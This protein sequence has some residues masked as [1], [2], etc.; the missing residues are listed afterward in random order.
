MTGQWQDATWKGQGVATDLYLLK[1]LIDALGLSLGISNLQW[2]QQEQLA[3]L[4]IFAGKQ[5][6]GELF[7]ISPKQMSI[8]DIKQTVYFAQI[9]VAALLKAVRKHP[10]VYQEI[11][12]FPSVQRDVAM[13]IDRQIPYSRV[14]EVVQQTNLKKLKSTRLFDVFES[15]KLGQGK[16]SIAINFTFQDAEKTL[17]DKE[18]DSMMNKLMQ[19]LEQQLQAEIRKA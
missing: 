9:E 3:S 13:I 10:V 14:E 7:E 19:Q 6:I 18:I 15:D 17:T 12:K 16:K 2:K 8:W 11:P 5:Q 4:Q 1:G